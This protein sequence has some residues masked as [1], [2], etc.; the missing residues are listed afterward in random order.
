MAGWDAAQACECGRP[1]QKRR[2]GAHRAMGQTRNR[3]Q[4]CAWVSVQPLVTEQLGAWELFLGAS[5]VCEDSAR[6][7]EQV[8]A[9]KDVL[10][11]CSQLHL[12]V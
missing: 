2:C 12:T 7:E 10:W 6:P 3:S 11:T 4:V 5:S 9:L 8:E 1:L